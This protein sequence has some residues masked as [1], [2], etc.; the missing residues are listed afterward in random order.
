MKTIST[1]K[2]DLIALGETKEEVADTL[3][4]KGIKGWRYLSCRCPVSNY[5]ASIGYDK[6]YIFQNSAGLLESV[7]EVSVPPSVSNFIIT[8]DQG[9]YPGLEEK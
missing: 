8:F 1:L 2:A 5:L 6:P 3:A 7:G 9:F 4:D